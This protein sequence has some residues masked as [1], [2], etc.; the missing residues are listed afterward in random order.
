M[1]VIQCIISYL[2]GV[3]TRSDPSILNLYRGRW[4]SELAFRVGSR[5]FISLKLTAHLQLEPPGVLHIH[6]II[7]VHHGHVPGHAGGHE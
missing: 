7:K 6:N 1:C 4:M 2:N 3:I 5:A